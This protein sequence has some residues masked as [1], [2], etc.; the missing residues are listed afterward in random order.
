VTCKD[1]I[2]DEHGEIKELICTYDPESRGGDSPDGRKVKGTIQWVDAAT[3]IKSEV[4]LYDRLFLSQNP[5]ETE[6]EGDF[7]DNLNPDSLQTNDNALVESSILDL[8]LGVP[9]QLE[10]IGYFCTDSDST[11]DTKLI[12]NRS[13]AM[14]DSWAK[15]NK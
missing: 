7:T 13:V 12:I 6:G 1:V 5:E 2:K 9:Y 14:R 11:K 10:R 3:A 8:P 15:N 4:R